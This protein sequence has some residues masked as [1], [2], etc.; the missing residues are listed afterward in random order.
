LTNKGKVLGSLD[1]VPYVALLF[2]SKLMT[3]KLGWFCSLKLFQNQK[4]NDLNT[5]LMVLH[6][7]PNHFLQEN[8]KK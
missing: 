1:W 8:L 3:F 6:A 2:F 7:K 5:T 4:I